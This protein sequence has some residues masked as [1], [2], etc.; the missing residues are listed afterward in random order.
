VAFLFAVQVFGNHLDADLHGRI[1]D[2]V[3][4]GK[5]GHQFPHAQRFLELHLVQRHGDAIRL[6]VACRAGVGR[7]VQQ[8]QQCTTVDVAGKVGHVRGH[9]DGHVH[10]FFLLAHGRAGLWR[11]RV[12]SRFSA[13]RQRLHSLIFML[14]RSERVDWGE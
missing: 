10:R 1:A 14:R 11:G 3:D 5:E 6:G 8:L 12:F 4:V 7:L 9:Q 13:P 2:I